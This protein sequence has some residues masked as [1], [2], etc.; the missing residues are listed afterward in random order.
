[1]L[2]PQ[3]L[4]YKI[5]LKS[6]CSWLNAVVDLM[7]ID[8]LLL[9]LV[10]PNC[11]DLLISGDL[12]FANINSLIFGECS[13]CQYNSFLFFKIL[14]FFIIHIDL[15]SRAKQSGRLQLAK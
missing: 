2:F 9:F 7:Y 12:Y 1:M 14:F 11:N 15:V 4:I 8:D 6:K 5:I 3:L 13:I 10:F